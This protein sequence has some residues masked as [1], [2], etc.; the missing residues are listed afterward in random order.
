[1]AEETGQSRA[2]GPPQDEPPRREDIARGISTFLAKVLEQL[3]R[4]SW[5]PAVFL[6]GNASVLMAL[7]G[8][9]TLSLTAAVQRLMGLEWGALVVLLFAIV[10]CAMVIQGFEFESLRFWEGY[11]RAN[12][13]DGWANWR[14]RRH[15]ARRARLQGR[16][17]ELRLDAFLGV[18]AQAMNDPRLTSKQLRAWNLKEKIYRG[19][20]LSVKERTQLAKAG[21]VE[22]VED[23]DAHALHAWDRALLQFSEYPEKHRVLPTGLGNALRSAEDGVA[24]LPQEDL[25]GFMIRHKDRLPA[26][27]VAEHD[28]YRARLDMYCALMLVLGLL[29]M[30]SVICF[31]GHSTDLFWRVVVPVGYPVGVWIC[32]RAAV[33]SARGYG[34]ALRETS[35]W[36]SGHPVPIGN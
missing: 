22:W 17:E 24:L 5:L 29:A 16:V 32:Y 35:N 12:W 27:I 34:Q 23:A 2:A 11:Y 15:G 9:Q 1:M 28:D 20:R 4:T 33:A 36:I 7:Q 8:E 19:D 13:I 3:S 25:E 18:K 6:V 21:D 30:V 26:T 14:I 10:I 31:S